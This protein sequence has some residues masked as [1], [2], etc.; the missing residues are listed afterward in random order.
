MASTPKDSK[1]FA[2]SIAS[3]IIIPSSRKSEPL[4]LTEIGKLGPHIFLIP[5]IISFKK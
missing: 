2:I 1:A 5:K 3:S 4:I